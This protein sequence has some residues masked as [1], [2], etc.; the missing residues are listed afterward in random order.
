MRLH[1]PKL[2]DLVAVEPQSA[3]QLNAPIAAS[4]S[5]YE[6]AMYLQDSWKVT[7]QLTLDYGLRRDYG[8][9]AREQH[10]RYSSFS[11]TVPNPSA[12]GNLGAGAEIGFLSILH[13][14]KWPGKLCRPPPGIIPFTRSGPI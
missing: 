8:T 14:S 11:L 1:P 7:R 4:T 3:A 9:Y 2:G 13:T 6:T 10:G 5:K 12:A